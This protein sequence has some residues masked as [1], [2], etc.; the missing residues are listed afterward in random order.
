MTKKSLAL[1]K[2]IAKLDSEICKQKKMLM[3]WSWRSWQPSKAISI[4]KKIQELDEKRKTLRIERK[5]TGIP[6]KK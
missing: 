6:I 5:A 2:R 3:F 1:G 4:R